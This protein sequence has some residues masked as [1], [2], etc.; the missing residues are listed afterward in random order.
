MIAAVILLLV[1]TRDITGYHVIAALMILLREIIVSGLREFL[2]TLQ[3]SMPVTQLAKWKTTFQLLAFGAPTLAGAFPPMAWIKT[4]R[5]I[6]PWRAPGLT[7]ITA[8]ASLRA[9]PP[10]PDPPRGQQS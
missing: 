2:A 6:S 3:V 7:L 5:L 4:D 10:S 1:F 8:P 9:R